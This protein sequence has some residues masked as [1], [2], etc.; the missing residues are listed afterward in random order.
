MVYI[1]D[2]RSPDIPT[3]IGLSPIRS[4]SH[5]KLSVAVLYGGFI[6]RFY[7]AVLYSG[8]VWR[9]LVRNL[10]RRFLVAGLY[11]VFVRGESSGGELRGS[12]PIQNCRPPKIACRPYKIV[13]HQNCLSPNQLLRVEGTTCVM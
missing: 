13:T 5:T 8:F 12:S 4:P 11:G 10:Y 9:F 3:K 2:T 6:W 1:Y 7:M